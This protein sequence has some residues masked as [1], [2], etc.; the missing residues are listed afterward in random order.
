M[1]A[2][3]YRSLPP[4]NP[5]TSGK[6]CYIRY[7]GVKGTSNQ[8]FIEETRLHKTSMVNR[9]TSHEHEVLVRREGIAVAV[10]SSLI[11]IK[12]RAEKR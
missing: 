11:S 6:P 10:G 12:G 1:R 5:N 4:D 9:G 3:L 8:V 2:Y 7:L